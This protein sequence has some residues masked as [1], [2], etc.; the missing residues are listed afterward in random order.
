[1]LLSLLAALPLDITRVEIKE[2]PHTRPPD[3][4]AISY[5]Q[6]KYPELN[7]PFWLKYAGKKKR[8]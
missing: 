7:E 4:S 5:H 3:L 2:E 6:E 1:M 8:K